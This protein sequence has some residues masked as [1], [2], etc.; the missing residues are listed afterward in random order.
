MIDYGININDVIQLMIRAAPLPAP[1]KVEDSECT[2]D[3]VTEE[4]KVSKKSTDEEILVDT[5]CEYYEVIRDSSTSHAFGFNT[6]FLLEIKVDD[7][8]D[9]KDPFTSS[10]VEAKIVRIAKNLEKD[11]VEYHVL[12][13]G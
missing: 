5:T 3:D 1:T 9:A 11:S 12:F 10:W 6:L 7:L 2:E 4:P 8:V 13:L